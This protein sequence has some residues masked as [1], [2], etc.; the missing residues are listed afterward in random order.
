M[1]M[2]MSA[3]SSMLVSSTSRALSGFGDSPAWNQREAYRPKNAPSMYT[4]PCAKLMS[5]RMP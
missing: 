2:P 4:S 5:L 3:H 1:I